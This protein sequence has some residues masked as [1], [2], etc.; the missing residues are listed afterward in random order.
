[1]SST[2]AVLREAI[3]S[4]AAQAEQ[5]ALSD[6]DLLRRFAEGN[7]QSAFAALV[8]RYSGMV[9][10]VCR[11]SLG[12]LQD[13]EDACQATFLVLA[14]KAA[15]R[16][17]QSVANWLYT[18]ARQ[19]AGNARLAA[20]RR[21]RREGR[22]AVLEVEQPADPVTRRELLAALEEELERLP[23]RYRDPL[24]LCYLEGLTRDE[25]AARLGV[26]AGTVKIHLERGRKRLGDALTRRGCEL[27]AGLLVLASQAA[28]A[29]AAGLVRQTLQAAAGR[30]SPAVAALAQGVSGMFRAGSV[31]AASLL[32]VA[33]IGAAFALHPARTGPGDKRAPDRPPAAAKGEGAKPAPPE[34]RPGRTVTGRVLGPKGEPVKGARVFLCPRYQ[35]RVVA[36]VAV[37][38]DGTFRLAFDPGRLVRAE[39]QA[40]W[41]D[42]RLLASAPG[43]GPVW[44]R[45]GDVAHA[46][47]Q[48]RLVVDQAIEGTLTTLEG[49]PVAGAEITLSSL[50][51]WPNDN[52]DDFLQAVRK[53]TRRPQ[54]VGWWWSI[55]G[56][57]RRCKTD[58]RGR[59]RLTGLGRDR[60]AGLRVSGPGVAWTTLTVVTRPGKVIRG[61]GNRLDEFPLTLLPCRHQFSLPPGRTIRGVVQEESGGAPVGGVR[62]SVDGSTPEVVTG[63]D[64]KF[65]LRGVPK[66]DRYTLHAFP[67]EKAI[68]FANAE[69][70]VKGDAPGL[71]E[72]RVTIKLRRGIRLRVKVIDK[73]TGKPEVGD[74]YCLPVFPNADLPANLAT[75]FLRLF[76]QPDGTYLGTALPGPCAVTVRRSDSRYVP[77]SVSQKAFF[78]LKRMP[79]RE[80]GG[81]EDALWLAG[82]RRVAPIPL[83]MQQFH[84]VRFINPA[85]GTKEIALTV[86]LD[87]GRTRLLRFTDERGARV[88]GVRWKEYTSDAWSEPLPGAELRIT[89]LGAGSTRLRM[90]RQEER[91]L[92]ADVEVKADGPGPLTVVLRPWATLHGRLLGKDGKP[93]AFHHLLGLPDE[94]R[95]DA[96]G[97]FQVEGLAA[98]RDYTIWVRDGEITVGKLPSVRLK[99][100]QAR[101]LGDVGLRPLR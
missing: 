39:D 11:C 14:R 94:V 31:V 44:T 9:L 18:T 51:A 66:K 25:V 64:G 1:V 83:P 35:S 28:G 61:R 89:G 27:G 73:A 93:R 38:A 26:P 55:P 77:A 4:V 8:G 17:R 3:R 10:R 41:S 54:P 85:K 84:A 36:E 82:L 59:Y 75:C 13:A 56:E 81:S 65:D 98:D 60:V 100:G 33:L 24:V 46:G 58:A 91:K 47:W 49:K 42:G 67:T 29:P 23:P 30:P 32:L 20:Q 52:L 15:G 45:L 40:S 48:A 5:S 92:A 78:K 19:I 79:N 62:V 74:V 86:E 71:A 53:G 43:F 76:R 50:Q 72:Q 68:G 96:A 101:D 69:V 12:N 99:A 57:P 90:L 37:A 21:A 80:Y 95:T 22:A 2:A 70:Q 6:R 34:K 7:D 87:P 97:R 88:R 16:W 63:P